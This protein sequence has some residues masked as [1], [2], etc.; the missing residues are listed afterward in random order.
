MNGRRGANAAPA[1][2]ARPLC[3]P[4][5][6]PFAFCR[7]LLKSPIHPKARAVPDESRLTPRRFFVQSLKPLTPKKKA[8]LSRALSP[9]TV[10]SS[11]YFSIAFHDAIACI[12]HKRKLCAANTT[13]FTTKPC[14]FAPAS[15]GKIQRQRARQCHGY[16]CTREKTRPEV[17]LLLAGCSL[18]L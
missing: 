6:H 5:R 12:Y 16:D 9:K 11:K 2:A 1:L 17:S 7:P 15:S 3:A 10:G 14:G 18:T 4:E 8:R 13:L